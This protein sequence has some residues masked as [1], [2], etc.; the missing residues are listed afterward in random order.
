MYLSFKDGKFFFGDR[1]LA[2]DYNKVSP[3]DFIARQMT[4]RFYY[5][6]AEQ[7]MHRRG[8]FPTWTVDSLTKELADVHHG[9]LNAL[10]WNIYIRYHVLPFINSSTK[11]SP[12]K[13]SAWYHTREPDHD[14]YC[15]DP[16]QDTGVLDYKYSSS[17]IDDAHYDI[18]VLIA[19]DLKKL[20]SAELS[21]VG[22]LEPETVS[23]GRGSGYCGYVGDNTFIAA[24]IFDDPSEA[25]K[26]R[27][28]RPRVDD[29]DDSDD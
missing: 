24:G 7:R 6:S 11:L 23:C 29:A 4:A 10:A 18:L 21:A 15:S 27:K 5:Y 2:L 19:H 13:L 3:D 26:F 16:L 14:G 9:C 25:K 20:H 17:D 8:A 12:H 1:Q 28:N 22:L